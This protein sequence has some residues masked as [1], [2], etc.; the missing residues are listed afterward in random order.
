MIF[1][2]PS[3]LT[4]KLSQAIKEYKLSEQEVKNSLFEEKN[5]Y[6]RQYQREVEGYLSSNNVTDDI[7]DTSLISEILFTLLDNNIKCEFHKFE[8][9]ILIIAKGY[10]SIIGNWL[11]LRVES[12]YGGYDPRKTQTEEFI[13]LIDSVN[14]ELRHGTIHYEH[15]PD[16]KINEDEISSLS[17][18]LNDLTA[19]Q[20]GGKLSSL[21]ET[22]IYY[23]SEISAPKS[24]DTVVT[25]LHNREADKTVISER[26]EQYLLDR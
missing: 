23:N 3:L 18:M 17:H 10:G 12:L 14:A 5:R 6:G 26:L 4:A 15:I 1:L 19:L 25:L 9:N 22:I 8:G 2:W 21:V 7:A 11:P 24:G 20:D 16:P 13:D